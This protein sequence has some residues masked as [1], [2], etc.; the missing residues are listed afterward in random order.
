MLGVPF[1]VLGGAWVALMEPLGGYENIEKPLVFVVFCA[2]GGSWGS[3]GGP[4]GCLRG[5]MEVLG[6]SLVG[7]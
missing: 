4:W 2:F 3:A 1:G 7:P 6:A 5:S